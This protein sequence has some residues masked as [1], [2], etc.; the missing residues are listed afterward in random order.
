[1]TNKSQNR[2]FWLLA[3]PMIIG[4]VSLALL[5][6]VDTAVIGHLDTA[7][8][9]GGVAVGTV[10]FDFLYWGMGFLR[11]GTTGIVAQASGKQDATEVRTILMQSIL[12]G[13]S[14][15]ILILLLQKPIFNFG[16]SFLEG[17]SDV[18]YYAMVYCQWMIWGMPAL[19]I[20]FS[21]N[22]W[23][24]GTQNAMSVL[25][26]GIVANVLN[27]ILDII[28][29][30]YMDMD[31]RGVALATVISQYSGVIMA[32]FI[33]NKQL[34]KQS[35]VWSLEKIFNVKKIRKFL[36]LNHDIFIRTICLILVFS[37]FTRESGKHGDLV[38]AA[39]SILL[40]FYMLMALALD[41]FNHAAEALVGK[42]IGE[43]DKKLFNQVV[44]LTLKW[45]LA[46]GLFFTLLYW[47]AGKGMIYLLTDIDSVREIALIYLPWMIALPLVSVWCFLLDGVFIGATRGKEMRNSMLICTFGFFLPIWYVFQFMGNH[48]LWL[49]FTLFIA[50]RG[51]TLGFSYYQIERRESFIPI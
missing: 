30:V 27:I 4:N 43:K 5:G 19:M 38:L 32:F 13:L 15:A 17:S 21:V 49:A 40:K 44:T 8:Y 24:L 26:I 11:M 47:L 25:Y 51:I 50:V 35:G 29:V 45:S 33:I 37:F 3:G 22:G 42:A 1:M 6:L 28:F 31:V 14:I 10:I 36:S 23:L 9:L 41:G 16:L 48:G 18:K 12:V 20:L 39:N 46:F 34:K 2:T 7:V